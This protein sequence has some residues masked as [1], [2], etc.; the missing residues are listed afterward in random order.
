MRRWLD[1]SAITLSGLCVVHCLAGSLL[2]AAA[3]AGGDWL[4]HDA[5]V[6]G[7]AL[8]LP[9]ATLALGRGLVRH[10]RALVALTGATGLLLMLASLLAGH[11]EAELPLSL[12]GV[13]LL[14]LAHFWNLRAA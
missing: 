5:H 1:L 14:A 9:L 7:L 10:G 13:G 2:L 8:A 11:G 12:A 6:W 3:A 4:G